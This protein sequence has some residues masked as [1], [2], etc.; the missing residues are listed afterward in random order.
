MYICA[1]GV[2]MRECVCMVYVVCMHDVCVRGVCTWCVVC[3]CLWRPEVD[4]MYLFL[5]ALHL[6]Y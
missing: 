4:V 6:M 5:A 1:R 3:V 2:C